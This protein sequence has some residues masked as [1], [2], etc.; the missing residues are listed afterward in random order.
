MVPGIV[1]AV[2]AVKDTAAIRVDE[3][4]QKRA[5]MLSGDV[6]LPLQQRDHSLVFR[7]RRM[8]WKETW[9]MLPPSVDDNAPLWMVM[10]D[11]T[12]AHGCHRACAFRDDVG[13]LGIESDSQA[14]DVATVSRQAAISEIQAEQIGIRPL[15]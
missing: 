13:I 9:P 10:S 8:L 5:W 7:A 1:S 12:S 14:I 4:S 2:H 3:P 6:T 15:V 11:T